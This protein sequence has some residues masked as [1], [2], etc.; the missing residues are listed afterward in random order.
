MW[1]SGAVRPDDRLDR[2]GTTRVLRRTL[3][4]LAPYRRT[5]VLAGAAIVAFTVAT[6]AG[7]VLVRHAI[8]DGIRRGDVVV[9]NLTVLAY[10]GV[11]G[12]AWLSSRWQQLLVASAGE[13]FLR[14]L[15]VRVFD[16]LLVQPLAFFD[17]TK[18]G[19][20]VSRMTSDIDAMSE[21]VQFGLLQ[22]LSNAMIL[23][24][25]VVLLAVLSWQLLAL[26]LVAVPFVVVASVWFQ[27][28]SN[29]AYLEVRDRIGQTLS[30][31]QEGISGVRVVQ[32]FAQEDTKVRQFTASNRELY[33]AHMRTVWIS[34]W[35]FPVV[36]LAGVVATALVV[37]VG[38]ALVHGGSVSLGTVIAFVLLLTN[39]FEPIQ[40]LSMLFN[41]V[42]SSAAALNKI[43]GLLDTESE[44]PEHPDAVELPARG[45]LEVDHVSFAYE[46]A[47]R[48]ALTD[49]SLVVEAGERIALVGPTGAG[50]STLA[51]LM[52][53]LYDPSAGA[54]RFGGVDLRRAALASLR[55][56]I[57][58]VPQEGYLFG[59]TILDN[60]RLARPSASDAEVEAALAAIGAL[61]RFRSLPDGLAT[62]VR[63]RGS[64]LSAGERQLVSLARAA[65]VDPAVLVL[66]EATSSLDPGTEQAVERAV[67]RLS[68][69]RTVIAIAHRLSTAERADRVV[70]VDE[71]RVVEV[72]HHTE[73]V[74]RGGRYSSLHRS[75][76]TA[77]TVSSP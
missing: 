62:E 76:T 36:E 73:L 20:L 8:D 13:R 32:A 71:G 6:L 2:R 70:V 49:A 41:T 4:M 16:H 23:V 27:R 51:K 25:T 69:G 1:A 31:L 75:W 10:L 9:L 11:A 57:V 45:A 24:F 56:R 77:G 42:Q 54:V 65:L 5:V 48:P 64:R 19:V 37:G 59:G 60:V 66:D 74:G 35:Y 39:L 21:L 18:A 50:K 68:A 44:V 7:P 22:L 72:G 38:G 30:A 58:V 67:E 28:R 29:R 63:E 34:V 17:R 14:D 47:D 15:R 40:Q 53:R 3:T 46:G 33:D 26:C 12:L 43:Y 55:R 61:D 52:A